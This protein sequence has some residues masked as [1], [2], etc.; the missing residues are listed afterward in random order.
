MM[1]IIR[2]IPS[3]MDIYTK[4]AK[5]KLCI[6]TKYHYIQIKS[7]DVLFLLY[8]MAF[9]LKDADINYCLDKIFLYYNLDIVCEIIINIFHV[10]VVK[11]Q[12]I[13]FISSYQQEI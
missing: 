13:V 6:N 9:M 10:V 8:Y 4:K 12:H 3:E 11:S 7:I 2:E 5:E 1:S